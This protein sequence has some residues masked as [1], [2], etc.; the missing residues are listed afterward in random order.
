MMDLL[1]EK[2]ENVKT[3]VILGHLNPDGDCAGSC[4]GMYSFLKDH[5]P[6][7]SSQ[8]YLD[9]PSEKF[10]YLR[11]FDKIKCELPE[12]DTKSDLCICLDSGDRDRLGI[13]K[14]FLDNAKDS[15]VIDHHITN[16]KYGKDNL[17]VPDASS[18][19]EV[20]C[21]L[22]GEEKISRA[23]AECL[24][25]GIVHDTGV[26]QH[27]NTSRKTMDMAGMLVSKG[28]PFSQIISDSFY[29]KTY[30]QNQIL[31][32]A[33]LESVTF[34]DGKC[35]FSV[36]R[37]KDM[38]FYGVSSKDMD[39]IVDQLR[40]TDGVECAIF[41]YETSFQE[42]KVSMRSNNIVDVSKIASF[43][44]GGGHIRAAGCNMSGR[45]HD[46]IN[47]LAEHIE[48]QLA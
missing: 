13:F 7:I 16:T 44:G 25:T 20:L 28:I 11:D 43:F 39:G 42:F 45:I 22:F 6:N 18:T 5:Y 30:V 2:L 32:R 29:K 48:K 34:M 41:M 14:P 15:L 37:Q 3:A 8:V 4:L 40:I 24:Y 1:K 38:E 9:H 27:S 26:F 10:Q 47:N 23:T 12:T 33:L 19:C 46:V 17:V 35:I 21:S 31:G 36:V